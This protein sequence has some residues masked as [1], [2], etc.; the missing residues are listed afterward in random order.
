MKNLWTSIFASDSKTESEHISVGRQTVVRFTQAH[1]KQESALLSC[2]CY[3]WVIQNS[4]SV[5]TH[6]ETRGRPS[7]GEGE[8]IRTLSKGLA[9]VI[10]TLFL[11]VCVKS[12][13]SMSVRVIGTNL[14]VWAPVFILSLSAGTFSVLSPGGH[15]PSLAPLCTCLFVYACVYLKRRD[16]ESMVNVN[17]KR[18]KRERQMDREKEWVSLAAWGKGEKEPKDIKHSTAASR[19][20]V[21]LWHHCL[22]NLSHIMTSSL[23]NLLLPSSPLKKLQLRSTQNACELNV[24]SKF[25]IKNTNNFLLNNASW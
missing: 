18:K 2:F 3:P 4:K 23:Q 21:T 13:W 14:S 1:E 5:L 11:N 22:K 10:E 6:T 24:L 15:V 16:G 8:S 25:T 12:L 20:W 7:W 9:C 17:N 19:T